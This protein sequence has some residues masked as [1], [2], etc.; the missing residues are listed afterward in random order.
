MPANAG[1]V[2]IGL[3]IAQIIARIRE[4]HLTKYAAVDPGLPVPD[5]DYGLVIARIRGDASVRT[6]KGGPAR[7]REVPVYTQENHP[8]AQ[9]VIKTHPETAQGNRLGFFG[10][11]DATDRITLLTDPVSPWPLFDSAIGIYTLSSQ[12]AI[13]A[14]HKPRVFG[15]PFYAGLGLIDEA[16]PVPHRNRRL[17]MAQLFAA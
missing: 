8:G 15:Q 7:F 14:G 1:G 10:P 12:L 6:S 11:D 3:E 9:V 16:R 13:F 4:A 17:T 5:P 2:T